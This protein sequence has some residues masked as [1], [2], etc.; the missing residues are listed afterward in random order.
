MAAGPAFSKAREKVVKEDA[1]PTSDAPLGTRPTAV[2]TS[3]SA[4]RCWLRSPFSPPQDP[5]IKRM[6]LLA[7]LNV[8]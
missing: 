2:L 5:K 8:P 3:P 7:F 1:A 4:A 6:L